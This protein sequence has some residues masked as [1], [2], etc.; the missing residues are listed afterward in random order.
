MTE[1]SV[2]MQV[3]LD[4]QQFNKKPKNQEIGKKQI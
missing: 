2:D 4:N 1:G 3:Y